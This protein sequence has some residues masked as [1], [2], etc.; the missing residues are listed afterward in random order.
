MLRLFQWCRHLLVSCRD[1]LGIVAVAAVVA[2]AAVVFG[3]WVAGVYAMV[4][5]ETLLDHN[6]FV[7]AVIWTVHVHMENASVIAS[8]T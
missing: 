2:A 8:V 4:D 1:G 7:A 3:F 6:L 5:S